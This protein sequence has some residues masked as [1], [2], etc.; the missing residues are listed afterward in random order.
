MKLNPS[1]RRVVTLGVSVL[2]LIVFVV[3]GST[4]RVPYVALSPGPT[5]NTLGMHDG[6]P[7]VQVTGGA[8]GKPDGHLNLTTVSLTD[9]LTLFQALG[10]WFSSTYQ[11]QPR[12][13]YFPKSK[14][15]EQVRQET[16]QQ[17]SSSEDNATGAALTYL[18]RPT[19]VGAAGPIA[20]DSPAQGKIEVDDIIVKIGDVPVSTPDDVQK[21]IRAHAPGTEVPITVNRKGTELVVPV[22]LG[23]RPDD[24][25]V[26]FLG[27]TPKVVSADPNVRITYNVGDIGGPSAGLML[28]LAVIDFLTPDNLAG[29]RFIA[30][31]GTIVPDGTVG[32]IGGIT[33][34][35][36]AAKDAGAVAFLVPAENCAEA[37]GDAPKGLELIKVDTLGGAVTALGEL[38]DGKPR[39]HC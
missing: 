31:T 13:L 34:K 29:G 23:A 7:V 15:D 17:M 3:V 18:K 14:S 38:K 25:K 32:P 8:D 28:T 10:M 2:V 12:E 30:G 20:D 5:V 21:Q 35:L 19:A 22:K 39:P 24:P 4:A 27:I 9:G 33:H 6:K 36:K 26:A 11:L 37:T 1:R 16:A